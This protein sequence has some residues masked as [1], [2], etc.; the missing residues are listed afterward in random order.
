MIPGSQVTHSNVL[1]MLRSFPQLIFHIPLYEHQN[2]HGSDATEAI[3]I[4]LC[5]NP[6]IIFAT[7]ITII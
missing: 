7:Q 3:L 4:C 6:E 5:R 2:P 1:L